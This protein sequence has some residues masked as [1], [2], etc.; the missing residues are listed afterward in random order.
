MEDQARTD[1]YWPSTALVLA[2]SACGG[3]SSTNPAAGGS[4]P[5]GSAAALPLPRPR[6]RPPRG[7]P[8]SPGGTL[9]IA[10]ASDIQYFDPAKGY[11]VV[12]WPAER[13]MFETLITLR[14]RHEA[15]PT[16]R[17]RPAD[18][19][20]RRQDVHVQAPDRGEVRQSGRD[21]GRRR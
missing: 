2:I 18:R 21:R 11:D 10:W 3:T 16:P 6:R 4:P 15:R 5:G 12:S 19:L 7:P 17:H 9:S 20:G 14:Q 13:L 8:R 1:G